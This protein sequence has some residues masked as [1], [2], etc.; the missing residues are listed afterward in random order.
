MVKVS[1]PLLEREGRVVTNAKDLKI[2]EQHLEFLFSSKL[3]NIY[4]PKHTRKG[5]GR[6]KGDP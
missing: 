3:G 2:V 5:W 6:R 1:W 4:Q